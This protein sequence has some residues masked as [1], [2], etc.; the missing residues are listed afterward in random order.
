MDLRDKYGVNKNLYKEVI[1]QV[2]GQVTLD[3]LW[4]C[5]NCNWEYDD[6]IDENEYSD[7]NRGSIRDY[8]EKMG[9]LEIP[10][11]RFNILPQNL[12]DFTECI[13]IL[14]NEIGIVGFDMEDF[15]RI[16]HG[17]KHVDF[18]S[19]SGEDMLKVA[20]GFGRFVNYGK[21]I[22]GNMLFILTTNRLPKEAESI[23]K[24]MGIVTED[25]DIKNFCYNI[26]ERNQEELFKAYMFITEPHKSK[27]GDN[28]SN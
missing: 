21:C 6:T 22:G 10:N 17:S 27:L 5:D 1:C 2:C 25:L 19:I 23:E 24:V 9:L 13:S 15:E 12:L 11:V 18:F 4:I 7:A 14:T 28:I 8:K 26:Y 3:S 16:I 20:D